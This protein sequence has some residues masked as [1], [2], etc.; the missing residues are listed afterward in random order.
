MFNFAVSANTRF[1][2]PWIVKGS[3]GLNVPLKRRKNP[4]Y[5]FIIICNYVTCGCCL[6]V[7]GV[8]CNNFNFSFRIIRS[9]L[10][11]L[12]CFSW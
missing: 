2:I 9:K 11:H 1:A 4:Y 12:G 10:P 5:N 3:A 8:V 7:V 6:C